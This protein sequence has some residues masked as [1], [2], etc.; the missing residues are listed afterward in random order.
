LLDRDDV[1]FVFAHLPVKDN[2]EFIS[3]ILNCVNDFDES[4]FVE[5]NDIL[6]KTDVSLLKNESDL[7][8]IVSDIGLDEEKIKECSYTKKVKDLTEY[9]ISEIKKMGI[10]GTPTVFVNGDGI[11]GPKPYRVYKRG[12]K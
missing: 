10:Y 4:K 8:Q 1:N 5:F 9:Q 7:L 3:N 11:V 2:T 12:L 6:F